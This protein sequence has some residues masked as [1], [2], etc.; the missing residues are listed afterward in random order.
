[1]HAYEIKFISYNKERTSK[2]TIV[3]ALVL[4]PSP[5]KAQAVVERAIKEQMGWLVDFKSVKN[6]GFQLILHTK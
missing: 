4:A 1:M 3:K 6:L 2:T 5:K